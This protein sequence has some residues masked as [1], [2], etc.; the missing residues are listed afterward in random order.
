VFNWSESD[1]IVLPIS[2]AVILAIS[3]ILSLLLRGKDEKI[4]KIPF[5]VITTIILVLEIIKQTKNIIEGYDLWSI[6]LHFCSL[7]IYFFPIACFAKGKFQE[8]GKTMSLVCSA[9]LIAL[10]YINPGSI[11]GGGTTQNIFASFSR[12]HTFFYHHLAMLYFFCAVGLKFYEI[13]KSS[14]LY[15]AIGFTI[16]VLIAVP[17]AHILNVNFCNI[18]TSNIPFMENFRLQFGQVLY[19]ILMYLAGMAGGTVVCL[20]MLLVQKCFGRKKQVAQNN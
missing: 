12:F 10:F 1:K 9:W 14:F 5:I 18:L 16:Y 19:T 7:F 3:V 2:L 15:V 20:L 6:P 17:M 13:K 4:K 8:F 11:I